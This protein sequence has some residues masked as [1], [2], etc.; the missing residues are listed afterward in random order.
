MKRP[1]TSFKS[2]NFFR[3]LT[4]KSILSALCFYCSFSTPTKPNDYPNENEKPYKHVPTHAASSF[5]RTTTPPTMRGA[6]ESEFD[7]IALRELDPGLAEAVYD[8]GLAELVVING[9]VTNELV[10][11]GSAEDDNIPEAAASNELHPDMG[12]SDEAVRD[13]DTL[14]EIVSDISAAESPNCRRDGNGS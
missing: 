7:A 9:R 1:S 12:T 5:L 2:S 6:L 4:N 8:E 3:K 14:N 10:Q 13:K 11:V